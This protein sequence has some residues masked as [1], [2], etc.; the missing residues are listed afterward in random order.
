M[1]TLALF[2]LLAREVADGVGLPRP[3]GVCAKITSLVDSY[4]AGR[5]STSDQ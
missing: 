1:Q 4:R 2:T 3:E 5:G